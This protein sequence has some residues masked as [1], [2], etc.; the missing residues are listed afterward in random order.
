MDQAT[1]VRE[2]RLRNIAKRLGMRLEK[3]KRKDPRMP[4]YKTYRIVDPYNNELVL[5]RTGGGYESFGLSLD[6]VGEYLQEDIDADGC[7]RLDLC[8]SE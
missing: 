4:N 5:G 7:K 3:C 2:N 8:K 6:E 1:K